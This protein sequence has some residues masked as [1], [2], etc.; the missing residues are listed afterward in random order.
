MRGIEGLRKSLDNDEAGYKAT[1][2]GVKNLSDHSSVWVIDPPPGK[3]SDLGDVSDEEIHRRIH[4][5]TPGFL[6]EK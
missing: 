6:R 1:R 5:A 4:E 2:V 3:G